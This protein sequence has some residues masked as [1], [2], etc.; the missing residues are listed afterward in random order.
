MRCGHLRRLALVLPTTPPAQ[1]GDVEGWT[2]ID[3]NGHS[4]VSKAT[5]VLRRVGEQDVDWIIVR[6]DQLYQPTEATV[7]IQ[8]R[9]R[10]L[11]L[12][13]V[14]F[15]L[16]DKYGYPLVIWTA[17]GLVTLPPESPFKDIGL[18]L[19]QHLQD[20][21]LLGASWLERDHQ[22]LRTPEHRGKARNR[23]LRFLRS[24]VANAYRDAPT[25]PLAF[26]L[27]D[28]IT[29]IEASQVDESSR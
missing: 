11:F 17:A 28:R 15:I 25:S 10:S 21:S 29:G 19:V 1:E 12:S 9:D 22:A 4:G 26:P 7:L 13:P 3:C 24:S 27:L 5:E 14:E 20:C 6:T 18:Q 2:L 23:Q 16:N 8:L